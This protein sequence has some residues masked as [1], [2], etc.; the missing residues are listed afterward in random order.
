M[1]V[2]AVCCLYLAGTIPFVSSYK[3]VLCCK[4]C[5]IKGK[6][7]LIFSLT[8]PVVAS[9]LNKLKGNRLVIGR[10]P[11]ESLNWQNKC[12]WRK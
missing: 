11:I 5:K 8:F 2:L 6:F 7:Q 9:K 4:L 12:G 3:M 1:Y 10:L